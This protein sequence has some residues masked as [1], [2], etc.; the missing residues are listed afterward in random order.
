MD[1]KSSPLV[2]RKKGFFCLLTTLL[3]ASSSSIPP[4]AKTLLF[5]LAITSNQ[6]WSTGPDSKETRTSLRIFFLDQ[7]DVEIHSKKLFFGGRRIKH[8]VPSYQGINETPLLCWKQFPKFCQGP[9]CS[10]R[11]DGPFRTLGIDFLSLRFRI[12]VI[13]CKKEKNRLMCQKVFPHLT[14]GAPSVSN[15]Q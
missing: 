1:V 9:V 3:A 4:C 10:P 15:S 13:F 14:V 2:G 7:W 6:T 8:L 5:V 11:R 12:M